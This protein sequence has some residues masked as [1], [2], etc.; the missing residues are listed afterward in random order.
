MKTNVT[1]RDANTVECVTGN[2]QTAC[3]RYGLG[4][5]T[6]RKVAEEAHAVVRIGRCYLINFNIVDE[7]MRKISK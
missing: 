3:I 2:T 5:N 6:M 4:R 7:Y 1:L